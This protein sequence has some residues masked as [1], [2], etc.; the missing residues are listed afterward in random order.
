[1]KKRILLLITMLVFTI[2][3]ANAAFMLEPYAGTYVSTEDEDGNAVTGLNYGARVGFQN[4]GLML[5]LD[6]QLAT[7]SVADSDYEYSMSNYGLFV[8]YSFPI[9]LRIW[10]TYVLNGT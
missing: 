9:M 2:G 6:Y 5:G 10:A 3:Q 7:P 4:I 1:M 8:G